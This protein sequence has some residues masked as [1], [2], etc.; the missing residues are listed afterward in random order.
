LKAAFK[1]AASL[2]AF[3]TANNTKYSLRRKP[4]DLRPRQ[5]KALRQRLT[6]HQR[7]LR[8]QRSVTRQSNF[9][10]RKFAVTA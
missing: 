5:T 10:Q 3:N 7:K 8:T 1:N 4:L 6:K 2:K 9:P